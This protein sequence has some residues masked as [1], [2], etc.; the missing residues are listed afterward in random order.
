VDPPDHEL[1]CGVPIDRN[2]GLAWMSS[3]SLA[4]LRAGAPPA[5]A[6][7]VSHG[8]VHAFVVRES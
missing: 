2:N 6:A 1:D 7:N 5:A 3:F 8:Y 4:L